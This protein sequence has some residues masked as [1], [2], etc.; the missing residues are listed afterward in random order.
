MTKKQQSFWEAVK[1][2]C[3]MELQGVYYKIDKVAVDYGVDPDRLTAYITSARLA[4]EKEKRN[5]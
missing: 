4:A 3:Q 5:G 1:R 2:C